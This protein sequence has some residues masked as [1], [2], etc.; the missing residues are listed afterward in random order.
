[1]P[2]SRE[3][4]QEE[5]AALKDA[6]SRMKSAVFTTSKG[7]NVAEQSELRKMLREAG[8]SY[9]V[10]KKTLLRRAL[11]EEKIAVPVEQYYDGLALAVSN[12]DEVLPAKVLATFAKKH[13]GLS[14]VGG[15]VNGAVYSAKDIAVLAAVP[16]KMELLAKL[17]GSLAQP[18]RAF[19]QVLQGPS[20]GFVQVL[21]SKIQNS[22]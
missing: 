8:V 19:L 22:K 15:I 21:Q 18:M 4:K 10:V 1:M 2:K 11:Q 6:F 7:L 16:S 5:L 17:V 12:D 14:L 20:R 13:E 3:K 9:A